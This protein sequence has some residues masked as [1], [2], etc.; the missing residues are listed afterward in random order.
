MLLNRRLS[1][2]DLT[3]AGWQPMGTPDGRYY[4]TFNGQIYNYV[5]LRRELAALGRRFRSN[6]DT[7]V[8]LN[9][10]A[11]W[12][13]AAL[14]RLE[15]MFAFAILDTRERKLVL[16]RDFFGI[17][18]LYYCYPSEGFAFA[19][20]QKALLAVP[21]VGRRVNPERLYSY[22]RHGTVD[23]GGETLLADIHQ[24]PPGHY[25]ELPIDGYLKQEPVCYW[26]VDLARSADISF[27]E[28]ASHFQRLFL[29]SVDRHLRSDVPVGVAL[30]GGIDSSSILMATRFLGHQT[31]QMHAFSFVADDTA[32]SEEHWIDMVGKASGA[33]VHKVRIRPEELV[34]DLER[35]IA[36]QDEPFLDT[37]LYAQFRVFG[38]AHEAG[39]KVIL[40][41][42]GADELLAGY[43]SHV[44]AR[45]GS[46]LDQGQWL[47]ALRLATRAARRPDVT[48]R[49]LMLG[50]ANAVMA[51]KS[52]AAR[53]RLGGDPFPRWLNAAWFR[54][55]GVLGD[56][57]APSH[58]GRPP[59]ADGPSILKDSLGRSLSETIL[60]SLLRYEDRNAMN[61]SIENRVPFLTPRIAGFVLS[62]PDDYLIS[63]D[64]TSKA[65][66]R[67]A[68][69]GIVPGPVLARRDKI[70]FLTTERDW[71]V[72]VRPWITATLE[73]EVA[74][75]I[76]ALCGREMVND[77][78]LI[79]QGRRTY[80]S[81][82]WRWVNFIH[83]LERI[84][85]R[86][87]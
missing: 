52:R 87:D 85:G 61:F 50:A 51:P 18:P 36:I 22:L 86:L 78:A 26:H 31:G 19:S 63:S 81:R 76:P 37:R 62:L 80:D 45:L 8:L 10:Y 83:W 64:G 33:L 12:G 49:G 73:G 4:I 69:Q 38:L 43:G 13:L 47:R 28:A 70:A 59:R 21:G 71:L 84:G 24:L 41:G 55:R 2:I 44:A 25:L 74:S 46:F 65:V 40:T 3:D 11:C 32:I 5:E 14:P 6:S 82:V 16:A 57:S 68:M 20:E 35:L 29:E 23:H 56:G 9:A 60:P 79:T 7:E 48:V 42:Q 15:G 53:R 30:S 58:Y 27:G 77:W 67:T 72:A 34:Q 54:D 66:L 75:G 17:K 39:I 1:I